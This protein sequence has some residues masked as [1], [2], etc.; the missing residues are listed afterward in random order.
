MLYLSGVLALF[1][2]LLLSGWMRHR[3]PWMKKAAWWTL[4]AAA[5]FLLCDL[6]IIRE[7]Q[8]VTTV[9]ANGC[10]KEEGYLGKRVSC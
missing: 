10:V 3:K 9:L 1:A 8:P 7:Y 4:A 6:G 2:A 5:F